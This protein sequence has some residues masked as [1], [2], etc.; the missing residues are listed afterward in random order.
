MGP[1]SLMKNTYLCRHLDPRKWSDI[2]QKIGCTT[3]LLNFI[4]LS[5]RTDWLIYLYF[6]TN[7]FHCHHTIKTLKHVNEIVIASES[8]INNYRGRPQD[9]RQYWMTKVHSS[10]QKHPRERLD[11]PCEIRINWLLFSQLFLDPRR[12]CLYIWLHR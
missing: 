2:N 10:Q 7:Y 3:D 11:N 9:T 6:I 8:R 12:F 5:K 4:G 1:P